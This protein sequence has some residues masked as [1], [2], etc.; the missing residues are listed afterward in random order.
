LPNQNKTPVLRFLLLGGILIFELLVL[1]LMSGYKYMHNHTGEP[2]PALQLIGFILANFNPFFTGNII[3]LLI[4]IVSF[5]SV[6]NLFLNIRKVNAL[7][8][9]F[10]VILAVVLTLILIISLALPFQKT[11]ELTG[12]ILQLNAK[13]TKI[14]GLSVFAVLHLYIAISLCIV[15]FSALKKLYFFRA[16]WLNITICIAGLALVMLLVYNFTDDTLIL[17][18]SNQKVDAGVVLGAAV[19]GGNKPSPVLRE[20]INKCYELY[21]NGNVPL[22]VLTGGGSPGELTEAEV[23]KNE[24]IKKGVDEKKIIT[25]N[26]SNS[27]LEQVSFIKNSLYIKN[28]WK[29]VVFISDHFHLFRTKQMAKFFELNTYTVSSDTPIS[30]ESTFN[31]CLKESLAVILFWL[32]GIG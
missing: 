10:I 23:S 8:I 30:S 1:I 4:F 13:G 3:W 15:S 19:W 31:Y 18:S 28:N 20:R 26:R 12:N 6:I 9:N 11:E 22:I 27:T 16:L 14:L 29:S 21:R 7:S 5:I 25:E 32:F 17:E 2:L 24:L